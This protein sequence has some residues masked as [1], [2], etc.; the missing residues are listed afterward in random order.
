MKN[1]IALL[2]G[3]IA[4]WGETL[5][6]KEAKVVSLIDHMTIATIMIYDGKYDKAKQ[7]LRE[8]D[9]KSPTFDASRFY[10]MS[11][12][13][14]LRTQA[15]AEAMR[16]FSRAIKETKIKKYTPPKVEK[17]KPKYLFSLG[18]DTPK[19][20]VSNRP[21][22]DPEKIRKEKLSQLYIYLSQ[23]SYKNKNYSATVSA[24]DNAGEK[25]REN[26]GMYTL[27]AECYWKL[28][29]Y[30]NALKALSMGE[31]RFPKDTTLLKQKFY[32]FVELKLYQTAIS[33]AKAYMAKSKP[34]ANEYLVLGQMLIGAGEK[35]S[36]IKVLEEAKIR[37]PN[38]AK[39]SVLLGHLYL[40]QGMLYTTAHL[41]EQASYYD[42]K[43]LKDASEMYRRASDLPHAIYLNSQI[44]DK[45]E[46][47]KQKVAIYIDRGEFEMIIGLKEGLERY[48][49]LEDDT[50]RYALAY[51]YYI[52]KDYEKAEALFKQITDNGL[53]AKATLIRKNIEKCQENSL[54][55]I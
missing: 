1:K 44:S 41:F 20:V 9:K 46:K 50:L 47:L 24:L 51:A 5:V 53:F 37:F 42:S 49:M 26:A 14:A 2:V 48:K 28:K 27:R 22:F 12:M 16:S 21:P 33:S 31:K 10:T 19:K 3:L 23:A 15:Y 54:E 29:Q 13:V 39:I 11:G 55:C 40:K 43:Y 7:E 17:V 35:E 52:V 18:S 30:N 38:E 32:Y 34:N 8:V 45:V 4:L 6:A 25:G 36:A